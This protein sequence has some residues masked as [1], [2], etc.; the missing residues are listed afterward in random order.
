MSD[1]STVDVDD[2][3]SYPRK[4]HYRIGSVP[5]VCVDNR[6]TPTGRLRAKMEN[7]T[8]PQKIERWKKSVDSYKSKA[9]LKRVAKEMGIRT[10]SS[11]MEILKERIQRSLTNFQDHDAQKEKEKLTELLQEWSMK[12][13]EE[14][15]SKREI[16]L[17]LFFKLKKR[18]NFSEKNFQTIQVIL[19]YSLLLISTRE[20]SMTPFVR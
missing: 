16:C 12:K 6:H 5:E 1:G 4:L 15:V 10:L 20:N 2:E 7:E 19:I 8:L 17:Y 14:L 18:H 13:A 3:D 11:D 9:E